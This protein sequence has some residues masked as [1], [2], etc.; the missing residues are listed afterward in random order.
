MCKHHCMICVVSMVVAWYFLGVMAKYHNLANFILLFSQNQNNV[1]PRICL[2]WLL[3]AKFL[4]LLLNFLW[5]QFIDNLIY[6]RVLYSRP[7]CEDLGQLI[8][9]KL[10]FINWIQ[11]MLRMES[12]ETRC[13]EM[14]GCGLTLKWSWHV[15]SMSIQ[16]CHEFSKEYVVSCC[17]IIVLKTPRNF[18]FKVNFWAKY[19]CPRV[20]NF[21]AFP[22]MCLDM[23]N[24]VCNVGHFSL[25]QFSTFPTK[26]S[27]NVL[28]NEI[29]TFIFSS[30]VFMYGLFVNMLML[31]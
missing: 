17:N 7:N 20:W 26:V 15:G 30:F 10:W 6:T 8:H 12:R 29:K 9:S 11:V 21:L 19:F 5:R 16:K 27:Q 22:E 25:L 13:Y 24:C 1:C 4:W 14:V 31:H 3:E 18:R 2:N 28:L 23:L